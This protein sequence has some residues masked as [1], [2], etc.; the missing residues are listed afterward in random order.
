MAVTYTQTKATLDEIAAR[1]ELARKRLEDA[2]RLLVTAETDLNKMPENYGAFVA[3]LEAQATANPDD[4]A[5]QGAKAEKDQMVA[6]FQVLAS[7]ATALKSAY[8]SV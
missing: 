5:W 7:L 3:E 1:T 8:D 2:R 6:D 4:R